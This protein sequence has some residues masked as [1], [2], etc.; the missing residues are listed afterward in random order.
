MKDLCVREFED[1]ILLCSRTE[2]NDAFPQ[3]RIAIY[4]HGRTTKYVWTSTD[5]DYYTASEARLRRVIE[6]AIEVHIETTL[7]YNYDYLKSMVSDNDWDSFEASF[8]KWFKDDLELEICM[9]ELLK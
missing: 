3:I 1:C 2:R 8:P 4:T 5:I 7:F 9:N 6:N